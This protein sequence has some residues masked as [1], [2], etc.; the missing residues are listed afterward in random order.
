MGDSV[1]NVYRSEWK[2]YISL[3]EYYYLKDLLGG[4][5]TPDPNMGEKGQYYIRSL[6]FDSVDNID[7]MTKMAGVEMRKKIRIRIYDTASDKA[8]LEIKNRYNSYMLKESLSIDRGQAE[9]LINGDF[10][11]LCQH[12]SPV[13]L[14]AGNIMEGGL[15]SPKTIVDYEREAFIYPEHNVRITFDK[16][17]RAAASDRLYDR[18][19]PMTP[20]IREPVMVLEVKYDQML[21]HFI[22]DAISS[23]MLLNS[24]ISKYCMARQQLG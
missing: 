15:Y 17:I 21:P 6:Y 24:S 11:V 8:K 20:L 12:D 9:S 3:Q 14:K 13:A 2:F 5:M 23:A 18:D 10:S 22:K 1:L 7:Y 4:T 19:L 16:N